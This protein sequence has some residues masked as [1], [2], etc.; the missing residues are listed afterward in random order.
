[1]IAKD[2]MTR[3]PKTLFTSDSVGR[4][5]DI[6]TQHRLS[7]LPVLVPSGEVHGIISEIPLLREYIKLK[8]KN[9]ISQMLIKTPEI[10]E[11]VAMVSERDPISLVVQ[12]ALKVS[13]HRVLV[14]DDHKRLR[15]VISPKDL[16][17]VLHGKPGKSLTFQDELKQIRVKAADLSKQHGAVRVPEQKLKSY[18]AIMANSQL[19]FHSSSPSGKIVLANDRIHQVLGYGKGELIGKSLEILYPKEI[20]PE[21]ERGLKRILANHSAQVLTS[22]LTKSGDRV[23]VEVGSQP[24]LDD[25]H[26][27][28]ATASI[29]RIVD[30]E[31][32]LKILNSQI[33]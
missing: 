24:I 16:L 21:M 6:F 18:E 3:N 23:N 8:A 7:T 22:Y 32:L 17:S 29:A 15:G 5:A 19:M 11:D 13:H 4:A 12:A 9:Q 33:K 10:F 26:K 2:L 20:W 25:A 28:I 14:V 1:M 27:V 31:S 30:S